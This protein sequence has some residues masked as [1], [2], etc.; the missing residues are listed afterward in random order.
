[1]PLSARTQSRLASSQPNS[2]TPQL[3]PQRIIGF[4]RAPGRRSVV[5]GTGIEGN[6]AASSAPA[7]APGFGNHKQARSRGRHC[8]QDIV[9][10]LAL[11][12]GSIR[13]WVSRSTFIG[14]GAPGHRE[15]H[16]RCPLK[17]V[18]TTGTPCRFH[19]GLQ[20]H[21]GRSSPSLSRCVRHRFSARAEPSPDR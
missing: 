12:G 14:V 10:H 5:V 7:C 11:V 3:Y 21:E 4:I 1:M 18:R 6:E 17:L 2:T 19:R 9:H 20:R 13:A 16:P 15:R 8:D